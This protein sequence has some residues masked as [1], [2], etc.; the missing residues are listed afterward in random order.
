MQMLD[1][2]RILS[3]RWL[4]FSGCA[5]LGLAAAV[6]VTVRATPQYASSITLYVSSTDRT[7]TASTAYEASLLAQQEVQSYAS[8]LGSERVARELADRLADGL[9]PLQ[10]Q[11]KITASV[12]P[13]TVLLR[14][15][16]TDVSRTRA[17]LIASTL[18]PV[19]A[20]VVD[21]LE[22]PT[23]GGPSPVRVTVV[24]DAAAPTVPVSPR[25]LR[26]LALGL[27]AGLLA[28]V[29]A[30]VLRE[31]TDTSV[32]SSD[33]LRDLTG[34]PVLASV[35]VQDKAQRHA[36]REHRSPR[37]EAY[38]S[39]RTNLQFVD[40]DQPVKVLTVTS[41][42]AGE[43][44]SLTACNLALTLADAGRRV[45]LVDGDL[46]CP[47]IGEYLGLRRHTGLT[48][49]LAGAARLDQ[50]LVTSKN[51][52]LSVLPAGPI[53]PNPSELLGSA[54]M[55]ELVELLKQDA[56][57]VV[58]DSPPLLP[59]TDAAILAH[60]SDGALLIVQH[61]LTRRDQVGRAVEQLTAGD[62]RLLGSILN[63]TPARAPEADSYSYYA[64]APIP[65][66]AQ[67][68]AAGSGAPQTPGKRWRSVG[69]RDS[70][71]PQESQKR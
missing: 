15:T 67:L 1:Y 32:K 25:P 33:M 37:S 46:R 45:I 19:F 65:R 8:L 56:D 61:G 13:Q 4:L 35:G 12:I 69:R 43:G 11:G 70:A 34:A 60:I 62:A 28:G 38:R 52:L 27:V 63:K 51:R 50:A 14:A 47:R 5:L 23:A 64:Y 2:L 36:I 26:N 17:Q 6:A 44:K 53:P 40:V 22:Q 7:P 9:T 49:I 30:A 42:I 57:I 18:G 59:V 68:V 54:R 48:S 31:T 3:R 71:A 66:A 29:G 10:V 21:L 20:D 24:D 41:S 58:I 55:L 39:L 16:V